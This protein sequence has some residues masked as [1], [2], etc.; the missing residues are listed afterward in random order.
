M[1]TNPRQA[2]VTMQDV[3]NHVGVSRTTV[4]FVLNGET[5]NG[6]PQET[7]DRVHRA[8]TELGYRPNAGARALASKQTK[9]YGLITEIVI[10][11][12][13]ANIVRGAEEQAAREGKTLLIA[14]T[15]GSIDS[16]RR[17][18]ETMLEHRVEGLI[19]ATSWHR[20]VRL[21]A[22]TD[23]VPTV[24]VHCFDEA[25]KLHSVIPDEAQ[26]G[27]AATMRLIG[28]G[29]D[30]IGFIN[31]DPVIPAA[32]GRRSGYIRAL[33]Q[34]GIGLDEKLVI[35]EDGEADQGYRA[36]AALLDGARPPTAIFCAT[37][38]MAMGAYDAIKERGFRIGDDISVV[39]FDNQEIIANYLRPSL[40]TVALPFRQMGA[41]GVALLAKL[42]A[43]RDLAPLQH[44]VEC[45]LVERT[46]VRLPVPAS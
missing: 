14:S 21:P 8:V 23:E 32:I 7:R 9:L 11:P 29:H 10:A 13:A 17:A 18:I 6:I 40:T 5:G 38:R 41:T 39:G 33:E 16:D 34:A 26:G 4:S 31:L 15:D 3:A 46:S 2:K 35:N 20:G 36:A 43:N 42:A 45:P 28:A 24:L 30:R 19:Y 22:L 37:D 27:Y 44:I 25:A 12:Y 1:E